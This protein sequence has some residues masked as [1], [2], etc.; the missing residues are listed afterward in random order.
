MN[1]RGIVLRGI[2][3]A[4]MAVFVPALVSATCSNATLN[5][6]YGYHH[7][8]FGGS[9]LFQEVMGQFT[10]D[11]AGNISAGSWTK[12]YTGTITTG[13]TV[14]TY[15][16]SADCA[17]TI[18][19]DTE[20]EPTPSHYNIFLDNQNTGFQMTQTDYNTDQPGE[21]QALGTATCSVPGQKQVFAANFQTEF[22]LLESIVGQVVFDGQG[23]LS[24]Q[25]SFSID[26][27]KFSTAV[28][29]TYSENSDCTGT[30]TMEVSG[31]P[32]MHFNSVTVN[33]GRELY[34][35][36]TD[37]GTILAGTAQQ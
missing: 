23:N 19:L 4:A 3:C 7:G 8:R 36:E 16:I 32:T 13:T 12:S 31:R 20:D 6:V 21:G 24:G 18:T 33:S 27:V 35:L 29:G 25:A 22:P 34:L 14:G 15:S 10:A 11:G 17:G 37:P 26:L 1:I 2:V 5:G 30:V 9:A 28:N